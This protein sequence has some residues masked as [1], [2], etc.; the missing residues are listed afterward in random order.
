MRMHLTA[1]LSLSFFC[2]H[3]IMMQAPTLFMPQ[4]PAVSHICSMQDWK[5]GPAQVN[6]GG[7]A[8]HPTQP[9][10]SLAQGNF[11]P[12]PHEGQH[13]PM[14][15]M[16]SPYAH[17]HNPYAAGGYAGGPAGGHSGQWGYSHTGGYPGQGGHPQGYPGIGGYPGGYNGPEGYNGPG[18]Y[19]GPEGGDGPDGYSGQG[20]YRGAAGKPGSSYGPGPDAANQSQLQLNFYASPHAPHA[21][22]QINP[23]QGS[24]KANQKLQQ[25]Q[26][27][28]GQQQGKQRKKPQQ[29]QPQQP[30]KK[31]QKKKRKVGLGLIRFS[32]VVGEIL[33]RGLAHACMWLRVRL[34]VH[35]RIAQL[36]NIPYVFFMS[37]ASVVS[38]GS[39]SQTGPALGQQNLS[40]TLCV[41][42][43]C[44][45]VQWEAVQGLGLDARPCYYIACCTEFWYMLLCAAIASLA[46]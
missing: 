22:P 39:P 10:Q 30:S 46:S 23:R 18:G 27:Q 4:I 31:Q 7:A 25:Y 21:T 29:P 34:H 44:G 26:Q 28:Q 32:H 11:P 20:G 8:Q 16:G 5:G 33:P 14:G 36:G 3:G 1:A 6:P 35:L 43:L 15:G 41:R 45:L 13:Q 2:L 37:E 42:A 19:R 17:G 40:F 12:P 9:R 24:G 38:A